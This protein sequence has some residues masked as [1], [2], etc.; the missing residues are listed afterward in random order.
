M[1]F[2]HHN[3]K[4]TLLSTIHS[5]FS[6]RQKFFQW[7]CYRAYADCALAY[8]GKV[9]SS[10]SINR[11]ISERSKVSSNV[12]KVMQSISISCLWFDL[13]LIVR[14]REWCRLVTK[15]IFR[16]F[17]HFWRKFYRKI[18]CQSWNLCNG[19]IWAAR[20]IWSEMLSGLEPEK[21]LEIDK[22]FRLQAELPARISCFKFLGESHYVN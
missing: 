6:Q 7:K 18:D 12:V 20:R 21:P 10:S 1:T 2:P 4:A 19:V 15:T 13:R 5:R 14:D 17:W 3:G 22:I 16:V 11:E 9:L 8:C